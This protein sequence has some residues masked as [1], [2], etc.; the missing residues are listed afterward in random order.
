MGR[1]FKN[2]S[3]DRRESYQISNDTQP[4]LSTLEDNCKEI[5]EVLS[6]N[7]D[8]STR[9]L[10]FN[11][12]LCRLL[13][14]ETLID[15]QIVQSKI[16]EPILEMKSG[17]VT[18]TIPI[19]T[20]K[21][22]KTFSE[23]YRLLMNGYCAFLM[24]NGEIYMILAKSTT[25]R[26][27]DEPK[28]EQ[29]IRGNRLGFIENLD[30]NLNLI[31]NDI[32]NNHLT[33]NYFQ[34]GKAVDKRVSIVYL[35][36]LTDKSLINK[37]KMRLESIDVDTIH[38]SNDIEQFIE[39][40]SWSPFP[41]ILSTE[42]LDRVAG[43]L[44]EGRI[45]IMVDGS[46]TA[47]IV[48]VTFVAFFQNT[49]DYNLRWN[50]S[51]FVRILSLI[52][53]VVTLWLPAFYI[54]VV[55][56]HYEVIPQQL[57]FNVKSSLENIPFPPFLE[58]L[59]MVLILEVLREA[60]IRLPSPIAQTI[61]IVGGL[62]IGTAV[63]EANLISNTMIIVIAITAIF[64]FVIPTN[65]MGNTLRIIGVGFMIMATFFGFLG[66]VFFTSI[67]L[68]HLCKMESFGTPYLLPIEQQ[69]GKGVKDSL[70]RMPLYLLNRRPSLA[71]PQA[72]EQEWVSK[73]WE[74]DGRK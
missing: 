21:Q 6:Y 18:G 49:D 52:G 38:S 61:G 25:V 62:V 40:S 66:M 72:L 7:D 22:V 12:G 36:N 16:I 51:T 14:F 5:M 63:V 37:V 39:D 56:F 47:L 44:L 30:V 9:S 73:D 74:D 50:V 68:M 70:L 13:Y 20:I 35:K 23:V 55:S 3:K 53:F 17:E 1:V 11:D 71:K 54:A 60:A 24:D 10:Q 26:N 46:S 31:R 27:P 45:A 65:D 42:R 58:A 2:K 69:H 8:F 59:L 67:V 41:Q 19:R 15:T 57:V 28:N 43:H 48:P 29:V 34:I 64:S 4:I 33:I 32:K